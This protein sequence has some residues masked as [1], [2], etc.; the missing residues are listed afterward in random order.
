M[1]QELILSGAK[2]IGSVG[3]LAGVLFAVTRLAR[4][5][6]LQPETARKVIHV[7]LGLYCLTFPAIFAATWEVA[8][9][10]A[11]A[12]GVF[13][14]A[15]GRLR[16]AIGEGLHAVGR[17]SYGE[18]LFA[19]SVVLLF[20][21]KDGHFVSHLRG[22]AVPP[23]VLYVLPLL[24]LTLCDAASALVGSSYGRATFKVEAGV[25]SWEG[26]VVFVVTAWLLSLIFLLLLTDLSRADVI[27]LALITALF[28]ALFEAASWRGLDNL[29]IPLGLYFVLANLLARGT[30]TLFAI[31]AAFAVALVAVVAVAASTRTCSPRASRCS[32]ASRSSPAS[33]ASS[34]PWAPSS[35]MRWRCASG[36]RS[37]LRT[38]R[39]A[40]C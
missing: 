23:A 7:S 4:R 26:V 37:G 16:S 36:R 8:A 19:V 39:S 38:T 29:F 28:G 12:I 24:I 33:R 34:P 3:L 13:A 21:L 17:V 5:L 10:C 30:G 40:C 20:A 6:G 35:R 18:V 14:L 22:Q 31:S 25:K 11:L 9:T 2:I 27:A 32:S 1:T 15:R